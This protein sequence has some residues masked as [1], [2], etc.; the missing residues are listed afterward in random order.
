[1]TDKLPPVIPFSMI[2]GVKE[3]VDVRGKVLK[4]PDQGEAEESI[5]SLINDGAESIGICFLWSFANPENENMVGEILQRIAPDLF[6]YAFK[7]TRP[8]FG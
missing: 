2:K 7:Q 3:R 6:S 1:M 5:R 4:R 8:H